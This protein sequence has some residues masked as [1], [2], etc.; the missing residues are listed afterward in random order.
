MT[1]GSG[2]DK[3]AALYQPLYYSYDACHHFHCT[4]WT[5]P[6]LAKKDMVDESMSHK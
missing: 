3:G 2:S 4:A 5:S 1:Q 6:G